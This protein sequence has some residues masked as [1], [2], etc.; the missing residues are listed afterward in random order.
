MSWARSFAYIIAFDLYNSVNLQKLS[1]TS[2]ET[3]FQRNE[4]RLRSG[5]QG[6]K[7]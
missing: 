3:E 7:L 4:V 5:S 1:Y 6:N 2:A